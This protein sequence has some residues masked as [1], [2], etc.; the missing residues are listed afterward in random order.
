MIGRLFNTD[1]YS[2][3]FER[4]RARLIYA[5]T[6][7]L[8]IL[9]TFYAAIV[10]ESRTG[11]T[12]FQSLAIDPT[13]QLSVISV[14][15]VGLFTFVA[16]RRGWR[17]LSGVGPSVMWYFS[18]VQIALREG[19]ST[20]GNGI[21]IV[22]LILISGLL[23]HSRGIIAS[24]LLS[25]LT[26]SIAYSTGM[27]TDQPTAGELLTLALQV[28]GIAVLEYL[29]LRLNSL[30]YTE[31]LEDVNQDRLKLATLTTQ[32]AQRISRRLEL[33]DVLNVTVEQIRGSYPTI[34][35][36][37]IFLVDD[38]R[39]TA[40]LVASTGEVGRT[41]LE[42]QHN[43]AVGSQSVIGQVTANG[44][45]IV[46]VA[47]QAEGIHRR[48]EFL[49][50][51]AVEVAFP[52][53][54][55]GDIIGALD[56]QSKDPGAFPENDIPIFQS[57]A[58]NI[59]IAI[60]NARLAEQT[61]QRLVENQQLLEQMRTTMQQVE[62]LNQQLTA[63]AWTEY[64]ARKRGDVAFTLDLQEQKVQQGSD[65]TPALVEAVQQ[66]EL[67][68]N[69]GGDQTTFAVPLRVRGQVI[70]AMEFELENGLLHSEDIDLVETVGERLGLALE[71]ARL[72]DES[73][74]VAHREAMLNQIGGRL[75]SSTNV[76]GV[77]SEAARSLQSTLGAQRVAIRL[78]TPTATSADQQRNGSS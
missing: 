29:L 53:R 48:N 50:E 73:R 40:R 64:L 56:L 21:S 35:H 19:F 25:M 45:P 59:A 1:A 67:V 78:G 15:G 72:Y 26:I 27:V 24:Y 31:T 60:D 70:G 28:S 38:S 39:L 3:T 32:I 6:V 16:I 9:F 77:L 30:T 49:P 55:A 58:D 57:L 76:D 7:I 8:I 42:R 74:R 36:A 14:Y 46:A 52:L 62:R 54:I 69:Q 33:Q 17:T 5:A 51:T 4:D 66:N 61:A 75:Q 12:T 65:W 34:Y 10:N 63:Q 20:P 18:G 68:R 47:G 41:L 71:S 44:D 43:L 13:V 23:L 37:Q 11:G 22:I 2:S